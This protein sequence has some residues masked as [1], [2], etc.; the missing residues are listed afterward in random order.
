[1]EGSKKKFFITM[2][3]LIVVEDENGFV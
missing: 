1:V 2:M 3:K